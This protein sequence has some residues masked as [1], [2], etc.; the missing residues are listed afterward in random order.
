MPQKRPRRSAYPCVLGKNGSGLSAKA[1]FPFSEPRTRQVRY[2]PK[3]TG[4]PCRQNAA[5][6][7]TSA[8]EALHPPTTEQVNLQN[9]L[10]TQLRLLAS[11]FPTGPL[12]DL[13][14]VWVSMPSSWS[15]PFTSSFRFLFPQKNQQ[16]TLEYLCFLCWA[17]LGFSSLFAVSQPSQ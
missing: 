14:L 12:R 3:R 8:E 16:T 9:H 1:S 5:Q 7:D 15:P 6:T 11:D 2:C 17:V 10:E 4:S 13:K